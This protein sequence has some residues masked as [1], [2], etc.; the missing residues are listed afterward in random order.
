MSDKEVNFTISD[1]DSSV[2]IKANSRKE[3]MCCFFYVLNHIDNI[4]KLVLINF[5]G[6]FYYD[7]LIQKIHITENILVDKSNV[8]MI[9]KKIENMIIK[10]KAKMY[11]KDY[12]IIVNDLSS[13]LDTVDR[14]SSKYTGELIKLLRVLFSLCVI[15]K[16]TI[17]VLD[18]SSKLSY[19]KKCL[20][21]RLIYYGA[22][23]WY[24]KR[25]NSLRVN[26]IQIKDM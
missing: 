6:E 21:T 14:Y 15:N 4:D 16:I 1:V 10:I 26:L 8:D 3:R 22:N 9:V 19:L 5:K 17:I 20:S 7:K 11:S 13:L 24:Y 23:Y 18:S 25:D 12:A 2:Y